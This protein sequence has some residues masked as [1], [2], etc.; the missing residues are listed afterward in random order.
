VR[1]IICTAL[2]WLALILTLLG[3]RDWD[4]AFP[5]SLLALI[6]LVWAINWLARHVSSPDARY[7]RILLWGLIVGAFVVVPWLRA[8]VEELVRGLLSLQS[9]TLIVLA[10]VI[11]IVWAVVCLTR[12]A[13]QS[14]SQ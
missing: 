12:P 1:G 4:R 8:S 2:P 5:A 9:S 13:A 11:L 14:S 7:L 10:L 6:F 3:M